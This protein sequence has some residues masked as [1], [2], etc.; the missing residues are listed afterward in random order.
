MEVFLQNMWLRH[1][2]ISLIV[3]FEVVMIS[4]WSIH[5]TAVGTVMSWTCLTLVKSLQVLA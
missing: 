2:A 3:P 5:K 1:F 4:S